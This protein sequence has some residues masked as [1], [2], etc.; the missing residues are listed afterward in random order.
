MENP[1]FEDVYFLLKNGGFFQCHLLSFLRGAWLPVSHISTAISDPAEGWERSSFVGDARLD[2]RQKD[3]F[4][5]R[6]PK[7]L[8]AKNWVGLQ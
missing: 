1:P 3:H 6:K 2:N 4:P 8:E 7:D 5:K